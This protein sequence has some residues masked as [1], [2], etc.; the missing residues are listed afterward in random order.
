MKLSIIAILISISAICYGQDPKPGQVIDTVT[1]IADTIALSTAHQQ[2][3]PELLKQ[4]A[5]IQ[6]A[7]QDI[8][9]KIMILL[10]AYVEPK[11]IQDGKIQLGTDQKSIIVR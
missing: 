1:S 9:D 8:Q 4:Q 11:K 7:Q 10:T 2:L 5:E 3:L 6:K